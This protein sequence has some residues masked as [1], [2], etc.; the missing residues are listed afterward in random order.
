MIPATLR[1]ILLSLLLGLLTLVAL[2]AARAAA[3]GMLIPRGDGAA[4]LRQTL[5]TVRFEVTD[6]LAVAHVTHEFRNDSDATLEAVYYFTLPKGATTTD[7]AMWIGGERVKGEVLPR[8]RARAIY[9]SIVSNLRDPALLETADGE[10]FT[11]SVYPVAPRSVQRIEVEFALPNLRRN[12]LIQIGYP[13][14]RSALGAAERLVFDA[15]IESRAEVTS[16]QTPYDEATKRLEGKRAK[17]HLERTR[18][19]REDILLL[20]G[21]A[22]DQLGLSLVT[23]DPDGHGGEKGYFMATLSASSDLVEAGA[24]DRQMTLVIDRSGSMSGAKMAQAK[25]MLLSTIASLGAD[26]TFNMISFSR[27]AEALFN[28]PR[29]ATPDNREDALRFVDRMVADGDTNIEAALRLALEQP[30]RNGRPHAIVFIT[31]GLPTRGER[32]IDALLRQVKDGLAQDGADADVQSR[33][34]SFGVGY[35][36]NTKLLDGIALT[37]DGESG[38]VRPQEDISDV[39]GSFV[40]G[41][42]SP[43]ATGLSLDFGDEVT[44]LHPRVLPDLY[45]GRPI[46]V[47]GRFS[48]AMSQDVKFRG[49]GRSGTLRTSFGAEFGSSTDAVNASFVGNL[50]ASRHCA[51]L[52]E[53]IRIEGETAARK[54]EVTEVATRWGIVTPYTSFLVAPDGEQE[55]TEDEPSEP[56]IDPIP[57]RRIRH[58]IPMGGIREESAKSALGMPSREQMQPRAAQRSMA[59]AEVGRDAV[60]AS[61]ERNRS[62]NTLRAESATSARFAS[63]R[64][65]SL[66]GGVWTEQGLERHSP[67]RR[68]VAWSSDYFELLRN[69]PEL[70]EALALGEQVRCRIGNEVIEVSAR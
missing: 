58:E 51:D 45:P 10:L 60:E 46:T 62:R 27:D 65:F 9:D 23:F 33:L 20:V 38:Y 17:I 13:V 19:Q 29:K 47:F 55:E 50:W 69:H 52:L 4:P 5:Q 66:R 39:V 64:T 12:G 15:E 63:G 24:L 32:D 16:V 37:G 6:E 48:S 36:V 2:P 54:R 35:D 18:E 3:Q 68:I 59:A 22:G 1:R 42:A 28:T 44:D 53:A 40:A 67:D 25:E 26:D 11:A 61:I 30:T 14:S 31:D 70:R 21:T 56:E 43:I 41:L 49:Q 7:F 8:E 34:F 57:L